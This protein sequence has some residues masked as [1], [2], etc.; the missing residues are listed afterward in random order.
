MLAPGLLNPEADD[1]Q[2][3]TTDESVVALHRGDDGAV[4]QV[5]MFHFALNGEVLLRVG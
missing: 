5:A 4:C 3:Y 1:A 2:V